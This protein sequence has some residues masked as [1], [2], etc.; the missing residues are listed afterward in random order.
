[1]ASVQ[2]TFFDKKVREA[3]EH[4]MVRD[5]YEGIHAFGYPCVW[6]PS[7]IT[8]CPCRRLYD[9]TCTQSDLIKRGQNIVM[10]VAQRLGDLF[11]YGYDKPDETIRP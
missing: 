7:Q 5:Y 8:E 11:M 3:I 6:C 2:E 9:G 10:A 1:M 4:K